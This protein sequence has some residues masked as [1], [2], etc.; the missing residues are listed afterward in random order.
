MLL[1]SAALECRPATLP[2]AAWLMAACWIGVHF[3]IEPGQ[4]CGQRGNHVGIG[5]T[6]GD[7]VQDLVE[8]HGRLAVERLGGR[9]LVLADA[10]RI[11]DDEMRLVLGVGR[12]ALQDVGID[13]PAAAPLHLLEVRRASGCSA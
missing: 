2:P 6:R 11:D 12:D 4:A 5:R 9:L 13:D 3:L 8:R 10:D 7:E 1:S